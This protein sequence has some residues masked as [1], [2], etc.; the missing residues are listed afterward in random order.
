[1]SFEL[2]LREGQGPERRQVVT[3][4]TAFL[5]RREDND[6]VLP[7]TFVSSRHGRLF[8]RGTQVFVEDMG[9]TNGTLVNGVPLEPMMARPLGPDDLVEIDRL[10]LRVRWFEEA[11]PRDESPTYLEMPALPAVVAPPVVVPRPAI[12]PVVER[13]VA[14]PSGAPA[15]VWEIQAGAGRPAPGATVEA[16]ALLGPASAESGAPPESERF[17]PSRT[18][19]RSPRGGGADRFRLWS[20]G[21]RALGVLAVIGGLTLLLFVLLS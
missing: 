10:S 12:P 16:P 8:R 19:A 6:V 9:S 7:F 1:M 13:T 17:S 3:K 2:I 21:L 4:D 20:V 14:L 15:G 18:L 5:G 11:R